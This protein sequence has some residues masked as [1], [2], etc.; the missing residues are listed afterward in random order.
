MYF[1][2]MPIGF[3]FMLLVVNCVSLAEP[4]EIDGLVIIVNDQ[5]ILKSDVDAAINILGVV[6]EPKRK[7]SEK[8]IVEQLV[9]YK[10]QELKGK[11]I[12]IK[13]EEDKIEKTLEGIAR[14]KKQSLTELKK[15]VEMENIS[16]IDLM[17]NT[18]R[19]LKIAEARNVFVQRRFRILPEEV[20]S[21]ASSMARKA[22]LREKYKILHIQLE[23]KEGNGE[24]VK[25]L[26]G[27]LRSGVDFS[28]LALAYS[29]GPKA[30]KGGDWG[31]M[32]KEEMPTIFADHI[33]LEQPKGSTIGPFLIGSQ[34]HVIRIDDVKDLQRFL[35]KEFNIRHILM[36]RSATPSDEIIKKK[37]RSFIQ[38]IKT[39][40]ANFEELAGQYSQD[41]ESASKKG[42]LGYQT[43]DL[44]I[45]EFKNYLETLP[46]GEIS[47]P[48]STKYGWH[49]IE[50]IGKKEVDKTNAHLK[51]E[52]Y[53]A[54]FNQRFNQECS[55]WIQELRASA[56]IEYL[57][58]NY[59]Q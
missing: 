14:H 56:Y 42:V 15:S 16:Y 46:V 31:W 44:Y 17:E 55:A 2:G 45:S 40:K 20:D 59:E 37:L 53:H 4:L 23:A 36:K 5:P 19:E 38:Q 10:L 22:S 12:G 39:G 27:K 41:M 7:I 9:Q 25:S 54:I 47:E 21:L 49:I 48:F 57:D 30:S 33:S 28:T 34:L 3:G 58:E 18:R 26:M 8:Q 35:V 50:I 6:S 43:A 11:E 1:K 29:Q 24:S 13:I 51:D 52:A 32:S